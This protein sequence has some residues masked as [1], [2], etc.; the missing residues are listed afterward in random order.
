[1]V[2]SDQRK[3]DSKIIHLKTLESLRIG[4]NFL[5]WQSVRHFIQQAKFSSDP[6]WNSNSPAENLH[7]ETR[8]QSL[9]RLYQ[10][11]RCDS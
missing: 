6:G 8:S 10:G 1:M 4:G 11:S 2:P 5:I 7:I 3:I 9:P